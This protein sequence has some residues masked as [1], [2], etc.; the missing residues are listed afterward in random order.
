MEQS[1]SREANRFSASQEI[2]HI[3]WNLN[4]N[5]R[6]H[7]CPPPVPIL[8][9]LNPVLMVIINTIT[10]LKRFL[11]RYTLTS[12]WLKP[13]VAGQRAKAIYLLC[14]ITYADKLSSPEAE[15][16]FWGQRWRTGWNAAFHIK[17]KKKM[18][19]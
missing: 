15:I 6:I 2:P 19:I 16:S 17:K 10:T 4:V 12:P 9:Q 13:V 18:T 5:Y 14:W 8:S 1:P 7:Q 3:L 11:P